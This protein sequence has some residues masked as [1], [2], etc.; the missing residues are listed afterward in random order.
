MAILGDRMLRRDAALADAPD[1][2][3]PSRPN[4][5][6]QPACRCGSCNGGALRSGPPA[7]APLTH[8]VTRKASLL[9]AA[10]R[11]PSSLDAMTPGTALPGYVAH[12]TNDAVFVRFLNGVTGRWAPCCPA[13]PCSFR[14]R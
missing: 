6:E 4:F 2:L 13:A 1:A 7:P 14:T 10:P 12:V 3:R 11:L 9:A 5:A 8:Q